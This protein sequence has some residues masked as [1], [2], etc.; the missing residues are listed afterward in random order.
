MKHVHRWGFL[1][2]NGKVYQCEKCFAKLSFDREDNYHYQES[3]EAYLRAEGQIA[4]RGFS[5][6]SEYYKQRRR[7]E[8]RRIAPPVI[9]YGNHQNSKTNRNTGD[10]VLS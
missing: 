9:H 3:R 6:A 1:G 10:L 5:Q 8:Q 2:G 7:A 4:P